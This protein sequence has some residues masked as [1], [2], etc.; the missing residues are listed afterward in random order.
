MTVPTSHSYVTVTLRHVLLGGV[1]MVQQ[2][3]R[4]EDRAVSC[5][6]KLKTWR[7]AYPFQTDFVWAA[8]STAKKVMG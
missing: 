5:E 6:L 3:I 1:E 8:S 7:A 2:N 4:A